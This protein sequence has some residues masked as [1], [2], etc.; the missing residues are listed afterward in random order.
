MTQKDEKKSSNQVSNSESHQ[1]DK[2]TDKEK[3]LREELDQMTLICKRALADLDNYKK[4]M[5]NEERR[6]REA[7]KIKIIKEFLVILDSFE[8]SRKFF[9]TLP[10]EHQKGLKAIYEQTK[11]VFEKFHVKEIPSIGQKLDINLHEPLMQAPGEA[12]IILD[13][14]EKGY[15]I[16]NSTLRPAKVKVGSN[17]NNL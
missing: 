14:F 13:E 6:I 16:N 17:P 15:T 4:S 11:A 5:G 10:Q 3:K 1:T 12:G 2:E 9:E 8:R 7:E